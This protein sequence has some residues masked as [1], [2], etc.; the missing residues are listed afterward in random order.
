[1]DIKL[2]HATSAAD[3]R[4][5]LRYGLSPRRTYHE[6][7][8]SAYWKGRRTYYASSPELVTPWG[9]VILEV[10]IPDN[11]RVTKSPTGEGFE[12][13]PSEYYTTQHIPSK[14]IRVYSIEEN[15]EDW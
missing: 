1:M 2:Y 4:D 7:D 14:Y 6:K 9:P 13:F 11:V 5:I 10:E 8:S 12:E 15:P 3:Y